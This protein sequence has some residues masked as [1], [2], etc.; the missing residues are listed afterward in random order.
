MGDEMNLRM[1]FCK[2]LVG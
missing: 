2:E 1:V